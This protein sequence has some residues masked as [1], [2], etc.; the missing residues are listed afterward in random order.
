MVSA[1]ERKEAREGVRGCEDR[2]SVHGGREIFGQTTLSVES[3]LAYRFYC[4]IFLRV[5]QPPYDVASV[6]YAIFCLKYR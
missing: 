4:G 1:A 3:D 5:G 6:P 2:E